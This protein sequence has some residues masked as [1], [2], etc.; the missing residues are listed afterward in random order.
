MAA[1]LAGI[2]KPRN[3]ALKDAQLNYRACTLGYAQ[4][5][6]LASPTQLVGQSDY[7]FLSDRS[8]ALVHAAERRV[9]E[10]GTTEIT[11]GEILSK[12]TA[13]RFFVRSPL[14]NR[15][16]Q[17]CGIEIFV[18]SLEELHRSYQL[19]LGDELQLRNVINQ[20]PFGL[21]IHRN[22]ELIYVNSAWLELLGSAG[23]SPSAAEIRTLVSN[24]SDNEK[25]TIKSTHA[26]GTELEF[27]LQSNAIRWNGSEVQAV[28]CLPVRVVAND[29]E[30]VN[31]ESQAFVEKRSG[32]RRNTTAELAAPQLSTDDEFFKNIKQPMIVCD[33]WVPVQVNAAAQSLLDRTSNQK[34]LSIE[35]WFSDRER[36]SVEAMLREQD[37]IDQFVSARVERQN[38]RFSACISTVSWSGNTHLL[39][40]LQPAAE[41]QSELELTNAKLLDC[42]S[43]A[44]DFFWEMDNQQRMTH[45]SMETKGFLGVATDRIINVPL[46]KL[47]NEHVHADDVPEWKV[48][49]VDLKKHLPFR[50]REYQ[51]LRQDGEK[52]VVRLSGVPVFDTDDTFI[53]YRGIGWDYTAQHHSASIVAYHASHD[54]L[55]GLV[56]RREFEQR[57]NEA[58]E[59]SASAKQA[60]C[61]ID[62]DNFKR[63]NDTAGHL[64][65]DELLRQ[66]ST[67]FTGLVRKSDVLARLGG[68]EFGLLIYDVGLEEAMRLATQLRAEV[69]SFQFHWEGKS[70]SV[71]TSIGLV[72]ID[73]RWET[74]S[75][76]FGAAD[77]ACY[78]AKSGGRNRV[79]V[80]KDTDDDIKDRQADRHW[81]EFIKS[82][83]AERRVKLA[84]QR[85]AS[86]D[87]A[88]DKNSKIEILMRLA[89]PEGELMQPAAVIPLAER[90]G[91]SVKLDKAVIEATL[92]W[93]SGQP[94]VTD[95]LEL[96]CI[97]LSG[98]T[99][100]DEKFLQYLIQVLKKADIDKSVLC[101]EVSEAAVSTNLTIV[102]R[103]MEQLGKLG[104]Q[105]AIDDFSGGLDSFTYLKK[106]PVSFVKINSTF[107]KAILEDP[108]HYTMVKS[109]NDV[110]ITLGKKT[111]AES[112]ESEAVLEK[113]R[114][115]GVD[116]VQ[117]Y[118]ISAPEMIDF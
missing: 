22:Y 99:I 14:L 43:A 112:V 76:L 11:A 67:L 8:A 102:S 118:H 4:S 95:R 32:H 68:D 70:F 21:L 87:G 115:L 35:G 94:H 61:F 24:S 60:L 36:A 116:L 92:D 85:I 82:A 57:C 3:T 109:I 5:L 93:L 55:T 65:G 113:L 56:N 114:E 51:W 18:V 9:L 90:Y 41:R 6:Q 97:N 16:G 111:I 15:E 105:F 44:G 103:F 27:S 10:T 45:V 73:E 47:V 34:Y 110:A 89:S 63:V 78:D 96:C 104:C 39:V 40:S 81:D 19:L 59:V 52:R 86:T 106:L 101:F 49:M 108:V 117:G 25:R 79:A 77:A 75:A 2:G 107:I 80:Y 64:A 13:G 66:L 48:L 83:I 28:Y 33:A 98:A 46:E 100:A 42:V 1:H 30:V 7:D 17:I 31:A 53:G 38:Q 26:D 88:G 71:G 91:L 54:S 58:I 50:N 29:P 69:E 12:R 84:M 74:R 72:L 37:S 23:S 20:S 62:L